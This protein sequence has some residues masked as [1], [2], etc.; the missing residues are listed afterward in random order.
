MIREILT[1]P[2]LIEIK[3]LKLNVSNTYPAR[4]GM[5][6]GLGNSGTVKR[7][8]AGAVPWKSA[9]RIRLWSSWLPK[10][11]MTTNDGHTRHSPL[12]TEPCYVFRRDSSYPSALGSWYIS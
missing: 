8:S 6:M 2:K 11:E 5:M 12:V 7:R 10:T 9:G 3:K 1:F 4:I